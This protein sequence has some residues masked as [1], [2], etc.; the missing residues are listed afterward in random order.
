MYLQVYKENELY[1]YID[2]Y[3]TT[4][5]NWMRY[6]NP[7]Y[8]SEAQNLIACQYKVGRRRLLKQEGRLIDDT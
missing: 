4:R 5:A 8:S 1:Y 6:V 2:G 3:D 7:A